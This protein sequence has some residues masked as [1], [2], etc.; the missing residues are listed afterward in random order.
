M[1]VLSVD[2]EYTRSTWLL[3]NCTRI[4]ASEFK[5]AH[6]QAQTELRAWVSKH[7]GRRIHIATGYYA[8]TML[9]FLHLDKH[10]FYLRGFGR[11]ESY[12]KLTGST[13]TC[14]ARCRGCNIHFVHQLKT[15]P[16]EINILNR[17]S[18][19][20]SWQARLQLPTK[21]LTLFESW[22]L[23]STRPSQPASPREP[24]LPLASPAH[25][26]PPPDHRSPSW[27]WRPTCL[28][29]VACQPS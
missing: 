5:N 2:N 4:L 25:P 28:P 15:L 8:Y 10:I 6:K 23:L 18:T 24:S 20:I 14:C 27:T 16:C 21:C 7:P 13:H 12:M 3:C 11:S 1:Q 17:H 22:P 19:I 29:P 9:H 26:E